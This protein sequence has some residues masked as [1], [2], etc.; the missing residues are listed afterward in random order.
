MRTNLKILQHNK[1]DAT[2]FFQPKLEN[3]LKLQFTALLF[4]RV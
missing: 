1:L 2:S 3:K 4:F